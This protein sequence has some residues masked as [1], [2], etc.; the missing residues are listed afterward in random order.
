MQQSDLVQ[1]LEVMA[2]RR[3]GQVERVGQVAHARLAAGVG[4]DQ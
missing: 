3:L 1:H 2:D 4:G